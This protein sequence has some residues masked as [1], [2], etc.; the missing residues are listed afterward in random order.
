MAL[1]DIIEAIERETAE[2]IAAIEA[3]AQR[4]AA[5][6]RARGAAEAAEIEA[7]AASARAS[8]AEMGADRIRNRARRDAERQLQ[9]ARNAIVAELFDGV[10]HRLAGLRGS[11]G[12]DEALVQL[13]VEARAALPE[14]TVLRVGTADEALAHA[15]FGDHDV[16]IVADLDTWCGGRVECSD[17]RAVDN[18]IEQR[19]TRADPHMRRLVLELMPEL[20]GRPHE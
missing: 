7:E 4:R 5:E 6:I 3:A 13:V 19:L 20:G 9:T 11:Q 16:Q 18:T 15:L 2:E 8:E 1:D 12:Y 17:G 10:R 14:A